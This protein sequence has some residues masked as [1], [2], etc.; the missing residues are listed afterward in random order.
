MEAPRSHSHQRMVF[1]FIRR[2]KNCMRRRHTYIYIVLAVLII[3][4]G[5][6]LFGGIYFRWY[7]APYNATAKTIAPGVSPCL[8]RRTTSIQSSRDVYTDRVF[9]MLGFSITCSDGTESR[10]S[11]AYS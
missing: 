7:T 4:S 6:G 1:R 3:G 11:S 10:M 9:R 5:I 8:S 2:Y